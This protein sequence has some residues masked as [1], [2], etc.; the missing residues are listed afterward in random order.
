MNLM[1]RCSLTVFLIACLLLAACA[2]QIPIP[3]YLTPTVDPSQ[4]PPQSEAYG[5]VQLASLQTTP[6]PTVALT[7]RRQV[8]VRGPIVGPAYTPPPTNTPLPT[9]TPAASTTPDASITPPAGATEPV[10]GVPNLDPNRIGIQIDTN[11]EQSDWE[12]AMFRIKDH[13]G[14]TWLKLQIP[15]EDMQPNGPDDISPYFRRVQLYV[16]DAD[17]RQLNILLSVVKAPAWA[18]PTLEEDG[19]PSDPQAFANFLSLMLR[20]FGGAIDAVEIWNEPN[21]I[22][23]WR[24]TIP[25]NGAGYMQ[26]FAPAYVAIRAYSPTLTIVTA[27]L[28]PTSTG[29]GSVDDRDYLRQMY[30]AGLA[31]YRDIV[32]GTHPYS[33]GN[34]PDATCCGAR[35]WDDDPHFF[36]AD[37]IREY[38]DIMVANGHADLDLWVT[39]FGWATWDAFPGDVPADSQWMRFNDRWVQATY[40]IRA[41]EIGQ[42]SD[43]IGV[44][45]LWNLNFATLAGMIENR[46]ERAAYSIVIPGTL[47][48]VD[49]QSTDTTERPLYWMIHD[50]VRPDV[51]LPTYDC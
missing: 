35:G 31:N 34:S 7:P 13:L 28:A 1:I 19:T 24:G 49:T 45:I 32:I 12:N 25:F 9:I 3:V 47:C 15:W 33:W 39:E 23:E 44:M 14:T 36:F 29:G 4:V 20:E 22:R 11:L 6:V 27:G 5:Q 2:T 17:R 46:D 43:Y 51:Q 18:R 26:L 21:L 50:A 42:A 37:T 8:T 16:E 48:V 30:A 38:R 41:F 10:S 40:T